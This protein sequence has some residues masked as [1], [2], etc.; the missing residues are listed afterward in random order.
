MKSS[1]LTFISDMCVFT[2]VHTRSHVLCCHFRDLKPVPKKTAHVHP[3]AIQ[4][5]KIELRYFP[6][7]TSCRMK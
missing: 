7:L 1:F 4:D 3:A 2:E 6:A 5:I